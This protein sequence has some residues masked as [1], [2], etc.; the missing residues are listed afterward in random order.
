VVAADAFERRAWREAYDALAA[1]PSLDV[2]DIER[3]ATAAYLIG[4]DEASCQAW[5][6][7]HFACLA[8]GDIERA[9]RCAFWLG[10]VLH[11]R[12]ETARG[13]GWRARAER[14][15][16]GAGPWCAARGFLLVAAFLDALDAGDMATAAATSAEIVD[17]AGR[18]GD[19]DLLALGLLCRGQA[20]LA[21]GDV[22]AGLKLLDE[23][24]VSVTTGEVSPIPA[25]IVY[26]AVIE[27]CVDVFELRRAAEW[28]E[29]LHEWCV[30][31]PDLV[32]YRGQCLVHRSQLLQAHGEWADALVEADRAA[33]RLSD[34]F[35]PALGIARYQQGELY[36]LRGELADA[37]RAYRAAG[38]LGR[39]PSPGIALLRLE[40]GDIEAALVAIRRMLAERTDLHTRPPVLA[41][42]VDIHLA[43]GDVDAAR[44]ACDELT[45]AAEVIDTAVLHAIADGAAGTVLL[46]EGDADRA[47]V[48]LRRT[49]ARWRELGMPYELARARVALARACL[50][51]G[52]HDAAG[53]E[54]DAARA[55]FARLGARPDLARVDALAGRAD[56][57]G[58]LS[59]RELEVLRLIATGS[60]NREIAERL[61]IS[62][63]TVARHVQN[64]FLKLQL[65]SRAAATAYAYEHGLVVRTDHAPPSR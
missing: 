58:P 55:T 20:S 65:S 2:D 26:C 27:A 17:I 34:P 54:L 52:D 4:E 63:H 31:E 6:R 39:D 24:M 33:A 43:A 25:G 53:L 47:L 22:A 49:S 12:G 59:E 61:V 42:A 41:A 44:A 62:A 60:T 35:H 14:L 5:E 13:N 51:V 57:G 9:A 11:L 38:E 23:A 56:H 32:P 46:A 1:V 10:F 40:E 30:S 37:A 29:A 36:R 64:I 7:A 15:L 19:R 8:A 16:E 28:T 18:C 21:Q 3:L 45:R 48:A 50:A